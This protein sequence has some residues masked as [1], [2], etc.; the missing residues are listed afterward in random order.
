MVKALT[1]KAREVALLWRAK[2][3]VFHCP[4]A[5][6]QGVAGQH[7]FGGMNIMNRHVVVKYTGNA[8]E[9]LKPPLRRFE[10]DT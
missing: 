9:R 6:C 4:Y 5:L 7:Y 10:A 1:M 2:N 8:I 3:R